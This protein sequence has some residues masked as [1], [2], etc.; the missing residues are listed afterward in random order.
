MKEMSLSKKGKWW[1]AMFC[2][3]A[4]L[5]SVAGCGSKSS[6]KDDNVTWGRADAKE[7]DI[8][9][10]ISGRVVELL[11][12]EGDH[13]KA[14]QVIAH[15]DKRDL[16]A[17]KDQLNAAIEALQAQ[18]T[19]ASATT[20]MQSGT[21]SSALSQAQA[22]RDKARADLALCESDYQRYSD[23]V[24]SGAVSRQVYEQYATKYNVAQAAYAQ[25]DSAVAQ[26]SSGLMVTSVNQAGESAVAKKIAQAEAQ[27]EQLEVSLDET[28]IKA[29][30]DGVITKKYIEEGSMISTGTPLVAVQDPEDNWVDIKVP[31]TQLGDFKVDQD[32]ELL[33]RDGKT[34]VT[35]T[36][37]DI[38]KKAEY[39][40]QRATSERGDESDIVSFNVKIQV[41]APELRPG[42]RFRLVGEAK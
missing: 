8:N 34:K 3:A 36:I 2:L 7:I 28:E 31:E 24:E 27:L 22:A 6:G 16:E 4:L 19:Q 9:S 42:M 29:P 11:V 33:A 26:A 5:L 13:V 39:A 35:G 21:S 18:Q 25:A 32:V 38:S 15:I 41:N 40:T 17:Q 10:K 1:A 20:S 12:K 30:F 37:T 14:G 23:L